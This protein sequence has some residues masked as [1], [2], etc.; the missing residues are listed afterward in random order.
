MNDPT[1]LR[2]V[3]WNAKVGRKPV[4]FARQLELAL[5]RTAADVVILTE[6]VAY[7]ATLRGFLVGWQVRHAHGWPEARNI[8]VLVRNGLP[9]RR[10]VGIRNWRS[11][12]GPKLGKAHVGRTFLLVDIGTRWR[13]VGVHRTSGG[14]NGPNAP[15]WAEEHRR[16]ARLADRPGSH[17]RALVIAGDQNCEAD[18]RHPLSIGGLADT[19]GG[20]V[21]ATHTKVDHAI[22][23]DVTGRGTRHDYYG[24]DHP[25][26]A[27]TFT[28]KE[29]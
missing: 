4:E 11:W 24:S 12:V 16:L 2:I 5:S 21:V 1:T 29:S 26:V 19:I 25:L 22:V 13:I 20:H 10:V 18:D 23:R 7:A 15:A 8:V 14:P 17:R 28:L 9:I 6:A 27:Y 3:A